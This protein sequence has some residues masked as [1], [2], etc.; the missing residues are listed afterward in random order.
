M[1]ALRA[2]Y[3]GKKREAVDSNHCQPEY[4]KEGLKSLNQGMDKSHR[5]DGQRDTWAGRFLP[6]TQ[7]RCFVDFL[8]GI[9]YV[10]DNGKGLVVCCNNGT[11]S[12]HVL[13]LFFK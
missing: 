3:I 7:N 4:E 13:F 5:K 8:D 12:E 10:D 9:F 2:C 11:L 1:S 6:S